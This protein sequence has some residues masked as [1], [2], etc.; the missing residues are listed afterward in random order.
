MVAKA[1]AQFGLNQK[2]SLKANGDRRLPPIPEVP[3]RTRR[4]AQTLIPGSLAASL[5]S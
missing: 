2:S 5:I 4:S 1:F 3:D